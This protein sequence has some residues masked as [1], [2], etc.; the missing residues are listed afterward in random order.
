MTPDSGLPVFEI[1]RSAL[2]AGEPS[3]TGSGRPAIPEVGF[4]PPD[5]GCLLALEVRVQAKML[6]YRGAGG[7]NAAAKCGEVR[8]FCGSEGNEL[9]K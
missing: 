8:V 6:A 5:G 2:S 1:S 3:E 7:R 9:S 4:Q